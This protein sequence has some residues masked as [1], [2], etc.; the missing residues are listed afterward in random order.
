MNIELKHGYKIDYTIDTLCEKKPL[1]CISI[2]VKDDLIVAILSHTVYLFKK[3]DAKIIEHYSFYYD[4]TPHMV[5]IND[6]YITIICGYD[7]KAIIICK[8][9]L[10]ILRYVRINHACSLCDWNVARHNNSLICHNTNQIFIYDYTGCYDTKHINYDIGTFSTI[11]VYQDLLISRTTVDNSPNDIFNIW[12]LN[13]LEN[14]KT[15]QTPKSTAAFAVYNNI[16]YIYSSDIGIQLIYIN[17]KSNKLPADKLQAGQNDTRC[18]LTI[19]TP[20]DKL[21]FTV[22]GGGQN[23][24]YSM[25][26]YNNNYLICNAELSLD[27]YNLW[28]H[29]LVYRMNSPR[30]LAISGNELL[31]G[32]NGIDKYDIITSGDDY[33]ELLVNQLH[34]TGLIMQYILSFIRYSPKKYTA[35]G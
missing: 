34:V 30:A 5:F 16:L 12:D 3:T 7:N 8:F 15:F 31:Y 17:I 14:L 11:Y 6:N 24:Y 22:T 18:I 10:N 19:K 1:K 35:P 32:Y 29:K 20:E 4:G 13:T 33:Y 23:G 2:D 21:P 25:N 27:I 26:L 28:T 9:T